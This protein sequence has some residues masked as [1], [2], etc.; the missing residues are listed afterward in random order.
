MSAPCGLQV[1][2]AGGAAPERRQAGGSPK[3]AKGAAVEIR[4]VPEVRQVEGC[5]ASFRKRG[6]GAGRDSSGGG[7]DSSGRRRAVGAPAELGGKL[8]RRVCAA[9]SAPA[10]ECRGAWMRVTLGH[11]NSVDTIM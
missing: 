1:R 11:V 2:A 4:Q 3:E 10:P 5:G 7:R 9:Q 6:P 8:I